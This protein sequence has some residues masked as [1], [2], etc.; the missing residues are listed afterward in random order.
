MTKARS[1]GLWNRV[2]KKTETSQTVGNYLAACTALS[3]ILISKDNICGVL[4]DA[5]FAALTVDDT[6]KNELHLEVTRISAEYDGFKTILQAMVNMTDGF[7][8]PLK[9]V[10]QTVL[11]IIKHIESGNAAS[12]R[13]TELLTEIEAQWTFVAKFYEPEGTNKRLH[14]QIEKFLENIYGIFIRLHVLRALNPIRRYIAC[15]SF[16]AVLSEESLRLAKATHRLESAREWSTFNAVD[17][18]G[19]RVGDMHALLTHVAVSVDK[20]FPT[21]TKVDLSI[22]VEYSSS[23]PP[24]PSIFHGRDEFFQA[25][26]DLILHRARQ[27]YPVRIA[28]LGT[29][30]I[31]KTSLALAILHDYRIVAEYD[32]H[33]LF[34]SCEPFVDGKDLVAALAKICSLPTSNDMLSVLVKHL[35]S[36]P[37]TLLVLDNIESIWLVKA[38]K[39]RRQFE[40]ILATLA[41]LPGLALIVTS[42]GI[43]LPPGVKWSNAA[44][45]SLDPI[46]LDAA[47]DTYVDVAGEPRNAAQRD[48]LTKL[49][50]A[51]DCMPLAVSLLAQLSLRRNTPSQLL[52]RWKHSRSQMLQ[53]FPT[54]RDSNVSASISLSINLLLS[55]SSTREPLQLLAICAH[56]P[57]GLR[58]QILQQ[59][60]P[61]FGDLGLA[62]QQVVDFALVGVGALDE[63][64]M[65]SPVRHFVLANYAVSDAQYAGLRSIYFRIAA[66]SPRVMDENFIRLAENITPEYSNLTSFML[67]L[68]DNE[69]PTQ[70]LFDA[71]EAVSEYSYWAVPS[72]TLREA[73]RIRLQPYPCWLS[74]CLTGIGRMQYRQGQFHQAIDAL[75]PA[76]RLHDKLGHRSQAA[77]CMQLIGE[78][79]RAQRSYMAAEQHVL[80]ARRSF[81]ELDNSQKP[82]K[83]AQVVDGEC[84]CLREPVTSVG[85]SIKFGH[86]TPR[87]Y[88]A[89]CT[90]TLGKI[91]LEQNNFSA[92]ETELRAALLELEALGEQLGAA[93]C[94]RLLGGLRLRQG[95]HASAD[96]LL[97]P[98]CAQ[99]QQLGS[100]TDIAHSLRSFGYLRRSQG[101]LQEAFE[102][103][104]QGRQMYETVGRLDAAEDC[105]KLAVRA[106]EQLHLSSADDGADAKIGTPVYVTSQP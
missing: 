67:H 23:L 32:G 42:R 69:E 95:D 50:Q 103:F 43:I 87:F 59:L 26:V 72:L 94:M 54:G 100:K 86:A 81:F 38:D 106:K 7:P 61:Q 80:S 82:A 85:S 84:G 74:T 45:A 70:E 47:R 41:A 28:V 89:K 37:N 65:L 25:A 99:I 49:L 18:M 14:E 104:E 105:R 9:A 6:A 48:A 33:R 29:G 44:T 76:Q 17:R 88:A 20:A 77:W 35:S 96:E 92:A 3:N 5:C 97:S 63:L 56:L 15:D 51:V 62:R 36:G 57:D 75:Q 11:Q 66:S 98:A 79:L 71:V 22:D 60:A 78:C 101:Q 24:P 73:M 55:C 39:S 1:Y 19:G 16:D 64:R 40:R 27:L 13:I 83:G 102:A 58:P 34:I 8:W 21:E 2:S 68:I 31:G 93:Q 90:K 30:G 10:P 12:A 4:E 52:E 46:S 91:Y 53:T